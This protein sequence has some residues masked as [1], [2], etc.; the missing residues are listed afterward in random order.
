MRSR[1]AEGKGPFKP[2]SK[3]PPASS[4]CA[5]LGKLTPLISSKMA[6]KDLRER[7]LFRYYVKCPSGPGFGRPHSLLRSI[8]SHLG[9]VVKRAAEGGEKSALGNGSYSSVIDYKICI[10]YPE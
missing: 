7:R 2:E 5:A 3:L 9:L 6:G 10:P 4:S 1:E 8:L